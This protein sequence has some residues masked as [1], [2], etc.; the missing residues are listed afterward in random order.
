MWKEITI[1]EYKAIHDLAK[2]RP[3]SSFSDPDGIL[4]YG[5]GRPAMDTVWGT[6]DNEILLCEMRKENRHQDKWDFKFYKNV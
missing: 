5:Y 4:P 1:E 6:E 2:L 3:V